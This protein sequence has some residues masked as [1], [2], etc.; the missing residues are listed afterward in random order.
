MRR[1]NSYKNIFLHGY[2]ATIKLLIICSLAIVST[3]SFSQP[4]ALANLRCEY[5]Q[6]PIGVDVSHPKLSWE[7]QSGQRGV[8]QTA[9]RILVSEDS[10]MLLKNIGSTWDSKKIT[11]SASIQVAYGGKPLQA[12]KKYFWKVMVWDNKSNQSFWSGIANWQMGL[13]SAA[14]WLN[15]KWI[16]YEQLPDSGRIVPFAHGRGKK[17]WGTRKNVL[18]LFRKSFT[19]SKPVKYATAFI[20][21]LGHFEMSVNGEKTGDHFLDPGWT[22]YSKHALYVSFD[23]SNQIKQGE[24]AIGVMLGN[25]FYYIPGERYRKL[26]GAYGYPKMIAQLVIE[27]TDG[28]KENIVSDA[29]WKTAP[30]PIIFSSI[31][32]GEDYDATMEQPGWNTSSFND[33]KW[34]DVVLTAG[35]PQLNSQ[36]AEPLKEMQEFLPLKNTLLKPGVRVYDLGQNFSGIVSIA[37]SGNKDDTVRITPAELINDDGSANQRGSGGPFYFSYILKGEGLEKWKPRFTYYGFRYLQVEC[38]SKSAGEKLPEVH[39]V[40]GLH[41]RNAASTVGNFACSNEL[42]NKTFDLINWAIKS[43]TVSVFTDCPHREKLG[44]L[45]QTH[46]MGNSVGYNYDIAA[47][48]RKVIGDMMNAQTEEGLIPEIAPEFVQFEDPFRDSPEWGSAAIILPWYNY[49]WYGDKRSLHD[50]YGMMTRYIEY[51]RKKAGNN[52][53]LQGLGD[54]YDIG[55]NRPGLSQL[56]PQGLTA[57]A[58]YYYDLVILNKVAHILG[59]KAD[60]E[61]YRV[62]SQA[63]K[64][65]FNEKFFNKQTRQYGTGSQTANAMALYLNLVEPPYRNAVFNNLVADIRSRNNALTAGDIGYRYVIQALE[66]AGR[67]DVIFDMNSKNDVPGYGYQLAHGATALTES[68]QAL[69]SVSNNHFMLGHLMEW[70]YAGLAGIKQAEDAIAFNKIEIRPQPAGNVNHVEASFHSPYGKIKTAWQKNDQL[71]TLNLTIPPNSIATIYLPAGNTSVITESSK[72]IMGRNDIKPGGFQ[73]GKIKI[74]VAS[75]NYNFSIKNK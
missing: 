51:L 40:T 45:E 31:Y 30:S 25:G 20:S 9:Y 18:P 50:A 55:P 57:T 64:K 62:L 59:K 21:G 54:W 61:R 29:T 36:M 41:I 56:T 38:K 34:N 39:D 65:S 12:T 15:A 24:N 23:I 22:Q 68:W 19:I 16:A 66:N 74:M 17:E 32:G 4:L 67:S 52:I 72:S 26:T 71:F 73:N 33:K 3:N 69:P 53:L 44:W 8:L 2:C 7:L 43:N 14:D 28:T 46:L 48:S 6:N 60:A 63:V 47:L 37:V 5:R 1:F 13:L 10:L 75:G 35:P 70:F 58:I 27:F 42:F 49:K 11:S